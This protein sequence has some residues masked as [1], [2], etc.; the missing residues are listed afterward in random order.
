M[1]LETMTRKLSS[2]ILLGFFFFT[3]PLFSAE[4][5]WVIAAEKLT[6][7][8]GQTET[9]VSKSISENL[10]ASVLEKLNS[11]QF[12]NVQPS[13]Q[14][15]R[16]R[17][18]LRTDRI[19]L[20]LQLSS[21][22]KKR[23]AIFLNDYS[24]AKLKKKL[25]DENKK[26]AD[27]EKSLK[28]NIENLK[29]AEEECLKNEEKLSKKAK[30]NSRNSAAEENDFLKFSGLIKKI[31]KEED[32]VIQLEKIS[33]YKNDI[34]SLYNPGES[35]SKSGYESS[36]FA[37]AAYSSG[38]NTLL[39]GS[40]SIYGDY[41]SVSLNLY[42]Y[43]EAKK[44]ASVMEVGNIEE[45][46]LLA[47]SLAGQ[48]I[49][50][51]TNALP[52]QIAVT[53]FPP[54]LQSK[55]NLYIDDVLQSADYSRIILEA[56]LHTIQLVS[57]GYETASFSNFYEG[58]ARYR[59]EVELQ[60]KTNGEIHI[61]LVKPLE[62][63]LYLNG[64]EK[65]LFSPQKYIVQLNGNHALGE[66][67]DVNNQST[68]FYIP[69]RLLKDGTKVKFKPKTR[70]RAAY[71]D[72]RRKWMYAAYS[73]FMISLIPNFYAQGNY[74]NNLKLYNDYDTVS[75][76]EA[77]KWQTAANITSGISIAC[78]ALW[79]FELCRYFIAANSVLPQNVRSGEITEIYFENEINSNSEEESD[80]ENE[81]SVSDQE[82]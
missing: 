2:I 21:E 44:I 14:L 42:L 6:L 4:S 34:N 73:L 69:Q 8:K 66:F 53:V 51:L 61:G 75:Y 79:A 67:I 1:V 57:E 11:S 49:P 16:K 24:K 39:T 46:E 62:G 25:N 31:F 63:K 38:I 19:S 28:E 81:S 37:K 48:L 12:R 29:K 50:F 47:T 32:S 77:V 55:C 72:S 45:L 20:F 60:K 76:D 3:F 17:C 36:A 43:P 65:A 18:K 64:E 27:I 74:N 71:I 80:G 23:D 26:I 33:Y 13:E 68:F 82:K 7:G 10:P 40:F 35:A 52:T 59:V 41:I 5:S 70:D 78:G 15:E 56:G 30:K 54:E 22:Y 9:A 58:N